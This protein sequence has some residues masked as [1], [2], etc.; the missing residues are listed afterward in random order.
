MRLILIALLALWP[1]TTRAEGLVRA[2]VECLPTSTR[3]DYDCTIDLRGVDD[4]LPV[5]GA[6][7]TVGADMP[8]MPMM[9][10]VKPVA[11]MPTTRPGIYAVRLPLEMY[12]VWA[13][14]IDLSAPLR[15]R[16]VVRREFTRTEVK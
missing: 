3:L 13:I 6:R 10:N 1:G 14:R 5:T 2:T 16:I 9:H 4:G 7:L 11:A 12:G 8:S 15:D